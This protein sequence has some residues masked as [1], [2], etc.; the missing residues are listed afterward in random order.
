M[1]KELVLH[2]GW[3]RFYEGQS[4]QDLVRYFLFPSETR[5]RNPSLDAGE[6]DQMLRH[7]HG[8]CD[9]PMNA[10]IRRMRP[11]IAAR[12]TRQHGKPP[13]EFFGNF[14]DV[15]KRS[16]RRIVADVFAFQEGLLHAEN[17]GHR[18]GP[19]QERSRGSVPVAI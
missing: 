10:S 5:S 4:R 6:E 12:F 14:E 13:E 1:K 19:W 16:G 7:G 17:I 18:T 11:D 8:S 9:H 2:S 15:H 3:H